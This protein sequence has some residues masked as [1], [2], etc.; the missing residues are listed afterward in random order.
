MD[1]PST[2]KQLGFFLIKMISFLI[3]LQE[4]ELSKNKNYRSPEQKMLSTSGINLSSL[5]E[6]KFSFFFFF[7]FFTY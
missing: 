5:Y 6:H 7:F 2:L 3:Y 4:L 1:L